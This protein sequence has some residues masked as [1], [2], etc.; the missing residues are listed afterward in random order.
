MPPQVAPINAPGAGKQNR[1][2]SQLKAAQ[3]GLKERATLNRPPANL[4][5]K[6]KPHDGVTVSSPGGLPAGASRPGQLGM[7]RPTGAGGVMT[8][9]GPGNPVKPM[10]GGRPAPNGSNAGGS[11]SPAS[12][13]LP[14]P[15]LQAQR[16]QGMDPAMAAQR[17]AQFKAGQLPGQQMDQQT[18][19]PPQQQGL[20]YGAPQLSAP[21]QMGG[22][23]DTPNQAQVPDAMQ[24][25]LY[26]N[27]QNA[28][29]MGYATG[30]G[31]GQQAAMGAFGGQPGQ[32]NMQQPQQMEALLARM[33]QDPRM[34][35]LFQQSPP[36]LGMYYGR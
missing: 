28:N 36:N 12:P 29:Q 7:Q 24:Q 27:A 1:L 16:Y 25:R 32:P 14:A 15:P 5:P 34:T 26:Q 10:L 6:V 9:E 31:A 3:G 4:A 13:A 19:D 22:P 33:R 8:M 17:Y 30:G 11:S 35:Q 20:S 2:A 18:I 23:M 21:S